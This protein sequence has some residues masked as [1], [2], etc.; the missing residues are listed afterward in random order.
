MR[1]IMTY[2]VSSKPFI[3]TKLG[4]AAH[5]RRGKVE[6]LKLE[7]LQGWM[8][9]WSDGQIKFVAVRGPRRAAPSVTRSMNGRPSEL[10]TSSYSSS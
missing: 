5:S 10:E 9:G 6:S 4:E 3:R 2:T 1:I 8:D 7:R